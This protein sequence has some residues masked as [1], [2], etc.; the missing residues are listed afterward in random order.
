MNPSDHRK[1]WSVNFGSWD[2]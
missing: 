2:G 1:Q